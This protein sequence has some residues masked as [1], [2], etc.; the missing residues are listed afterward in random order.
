MAA[1]LHVSGVKT[2]YPAIAKR[3]SC[4]RPVYSHPW[5][6]FSVSVAPVY[7]LCTSL[8]GS[9]RTQDLR[10]RCEAGNV[11]IRNGTESQCSEESANELTCVMKFGGSSVASADRMREVANLIL[12]FREERPVIVLSAMGKTTNK[13]LIVL[14]K[15]CYRFLMLIPVFFVNPFEMSGLLMI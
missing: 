9:C 12:R 10:I 6:D 7:G 5:L 4:L 3:A 2:P 14:L 8:K 15:S 1:S 11:D 13:L